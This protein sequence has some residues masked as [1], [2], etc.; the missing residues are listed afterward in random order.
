[1]YFGSDSGKAGKMFGE[2]ST[3]FGVGNRWKDVLSEDPREV[4]HLDL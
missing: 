2:K 4:G 1:M 3:S